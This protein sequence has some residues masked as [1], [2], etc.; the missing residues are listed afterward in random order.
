MDIEKFYPLIFN[1][2]ATEMDIEKFSGIFLSKLES[3][4]NIQTLHKSLCLL[5]TRK[6]RLKIRF[7]RGEIPYRYS[8]GNF[9]V[10]IGYKISRS[11]IWRIYLGRF[12]S[13]VFFSF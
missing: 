8:N 5:K 3:D 1:V 10:N 11:A 2:R 13:E 12:T 6:P 7:G 9:H 4:K